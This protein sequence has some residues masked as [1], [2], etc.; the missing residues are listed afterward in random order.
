MIDEEKARAM[1]AWA[2]GDQNAALANYSLSDLYRMRAEIDAMLPPQTLASM[3]LE[4]ELVR[5]FSTV[6]ALQ[7]SILD[8]DEVPAN[9]RAQVAGQ[10][11]STLGQLV[12][13]QSELHTAERFKAIESLMIKYMKRLPLDVAEAFINDYEALADE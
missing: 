10:V 11:A 3:N 12:K 13:M 9:Q 4:E 5:Q 6:K 7:T 2:D 8:D 1:V